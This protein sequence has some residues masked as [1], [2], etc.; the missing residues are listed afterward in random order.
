MAIGF[1][2]LE[3]ERDAEG[4]ALDSL[5]LQNSAMLD[6]REFLALVADRLPTL[7]LYLSRRKPTSP[8]VALLV[9]AD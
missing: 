8:T 3:L 5:G 4:R 9:L 7:G 2:N 6:F 1:L